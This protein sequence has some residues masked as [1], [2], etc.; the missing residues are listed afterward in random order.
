MSSLNVV[1]RALHWVFKV[2]DRKKTM[3]FYRD[4]LGMKVLRH[5]EFEKGCDAQCNGPFD[6]KWSKTMVGYGPEDSHFVVE[7]T[8]NY[9]IGSYALGN[10]FQ[11]LTIRS[12][13]AIANAQRLDWPIEDIGSDDGAKLVRAPDGYEFTLLDFPQPAA[14]D[15]VVSVAVAAFD[16][17]KSLAFWRDL[18]GMQEVETNLLRYADGQAAL[19][20][21]PTA[22]GAA[23]DRGSA[24]GRIAFAVD[25]DKLPQIERAV[26]DCASSG[27]SVVT[28]LVKLDTPGKATVSVVILADPDGAEICFVGEQAF[29]DLSQPDPNADNLIDE[30]MQNDWSDQWFADGKAKG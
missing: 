7:L 25:E 29:R 2:G 9:G 5:E 3:R 4:V 6:G 12:S 14:A 24:F 28:P 21:V 23:I 8:Y 10:D 16:V 1:G 18:L 26:K 19:R 13:E 30:A 11:G 15:P 22:D 20:L 27:G 17:A